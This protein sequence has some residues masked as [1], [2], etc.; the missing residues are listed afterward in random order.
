MDNFLL[1]IFLG[2]LGIEPR[3][4]GSG[5]KCANH[6]AANLSH[7]FELIQGAS[8][9]G[10]KNSSFDY[11]EDHSRRQNER[12]WWQK[13]QK[14][15]KTTPPGFEWRVVEAKNFLIEA[16]A[17][18]GCGEKPL[19]FFLPPPRP[20]I[21]KFEEAETKLKMGP[22]NIFCLSEFHLQRKFRCR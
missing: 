10:K 21:E 16:T 12:R 7:N 5:S 15:T 2:T 8:T 6:C 19:R 17:V 11:H 22:M 18:V 13:R 20:N 9:L 4:A 14:T 3:A 1:W